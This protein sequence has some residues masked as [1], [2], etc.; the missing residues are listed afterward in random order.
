MD[1]AAYRSTVRSRLGLR[2]DEG[3][4]A[5]ADL[6]RA[7]NQA[8][9]A[10]ATEF[11]WPHLSVVESANLAADASFITPPDYWDR[12]IFLAGANGELSLRA[13]RDLVQYADFTGAPRFY[14]PHG[15]RLLV[16]P[17]ADSA[18]TLTHSFTRYELV[19]AAPTD[20]PLLPAAFDEWV[21]IEAALRIAHRLN[22]QTRAEGLKI[23]SAEWRRR[24]SNN[25]RKTASL[26][27]IRRT[28]SSMWPG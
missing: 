14:A 28:R 8:L 10:I 3:Q 24:A 2:G 9:A 19:L 26:P 4:A 15:K 1:L 16:A 18:Y 20:A 13:H 21:V 6:D 12:T 22:N 25:V 17:K 23:E 11:D 5:D 27:P 7:I